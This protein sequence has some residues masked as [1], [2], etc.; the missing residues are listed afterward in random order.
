MA[1][2][3]RTDPRGST[4]AIDKRLQL[5]QPTTEALHLLDRLDDDGVLLNCIE[6]TIDLIFADDYAPWQ[7]DELVQERLPATVAREDA[8]PI[9]SRRLHNTEA[10]G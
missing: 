8:G 6:V 10:T 1:C 5:Y 3:S 4:R 2:T 9:I 7:L